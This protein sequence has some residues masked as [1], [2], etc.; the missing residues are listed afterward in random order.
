MRYVLFVILVLFISCGS[1][2]TPA[3]D[4][5]AIIKNNMWKDLISISTATVMTENQAVVERDSK[6]WTTGLVVTK[7]LVCDNIS[8][9]NLVF[10]FQS[11]ALAHSMISMYLNYNPDYVLKLPSTDSTLSFTDKYLSLK[12]T[13][14]R[15]L[16][17][18]IKY[19]I[20]YYTSDLETSESALIAANN[21]KARAQRAL[22]M[23]NTFSGSSASTFKT[24]FDAVVTYFTSNSDH[25]YTVTS[26][27]SIDIDMTPWISSTGD[28]WF[29][30]DTGGTCPFEINST[31]VQ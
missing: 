13:I 2:N 8:R 14:S 12:F 5:E 3:T 22:G 21:D 31:N 15:D 1:S 26:G 17:T 6:T 11:S 16:E 7:T 20:L 10:T 23:L 4:D 18:I 29:I 24:N 25:F 28:V 27:Y 30:G 19:L 9:V